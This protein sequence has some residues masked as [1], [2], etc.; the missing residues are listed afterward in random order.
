MII[1]LPVRL[2]FFAGFP[3]MGYI[4]L[5]ALKTHA[6]GIA[7][8][9]LGALLVFVALWNMRRLWPMAIAGTVICAVAFGFISAA[10]SEVLPSEND[11]TVTWYRTH[12]AVANEV[13]RSCDNDPGHASNAPDCANALQARILIYMDHHGLTLSNRYYPRTDVRFWLANPA[14]TVQ[15]LTLCPRMTPAQQAQFGC[16]LA[17]SARKKMLADE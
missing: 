10:K 8:T 11:R 9:M 7:A 17:F 3:I 15:A 16:G 6:Y 5:E 14:N 2:L 1:L 4:F 13:V 12:P